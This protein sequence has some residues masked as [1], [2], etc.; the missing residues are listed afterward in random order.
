MH[1]TKSPVS[2]ATISGLMEINYCSGFLPALS[3]LASKVGEGQVR[4]S[5]LEAALEAAAVDSDSGLLC[6]CTATGILDSRKMRLTPSTHSE[7]NQAR[8]CLFI[9]ATDSRHGS[10]QNLNALYSA[11]KC[12]SDALKGSPSKTFKIRSIRTCFASV[13]G[14]S[15]ALVPSLVA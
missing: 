10:S 15:N 5:R 4:L 7:E 2:P 13:S 6:F 11:S 9:L 14:G 12:F 1:F 3:D 8:V